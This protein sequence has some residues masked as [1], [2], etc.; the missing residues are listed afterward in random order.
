MS[1]TRGKWAAVMARR[2][3]FG[4]PETLRPVWLVHQ[5]HG[6]NRPQPIICELPEEHDIPPA[7]RRANAQLIAAAPDLYD[8]AMDALVALTGV[9]TASGVDARNKLRRALSAAEVAE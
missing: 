7:E 6:E 5:V 8:A 3:K 4:Q 1:Y 2:G 9:V